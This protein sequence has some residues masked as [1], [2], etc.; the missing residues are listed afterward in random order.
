MVKLICKLRN[1]QHAKCRSEASTAR[2][3]RLQFQIGEV[4]YWKSSISYSYPVTKLNTIFPLQK[5][6]WRNKI[7][8]EIK[9]FSRHT[10]FLIHTL[11]F[12]H[13]CTV[14]VELILLTFCWIHL[15]PHPHHIC[16]FVQT[17]THLF[18]IYTYFDT[19]VW[20]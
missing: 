17:A 4:G 7:R 9:I 6:V 19:C 11:N 5:D 13:T 10:Y 1:F 8:L 15:L 18:T 3:W 20:G 2:F 14:Q 16:K 12:C